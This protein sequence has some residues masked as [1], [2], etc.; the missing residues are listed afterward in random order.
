MTLSKYLIRK[1][2]V[3]M[4]KPLLQFF[5]QVLFTSQTSCPAGTNVARVYSLGVHISGAHKVATN[6]V[7]IC[8]LLAHNHIIVAQYIINDYM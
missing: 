7:H 8:Q 4:L 3:Q 6:F 1:A 2:Y 5:H